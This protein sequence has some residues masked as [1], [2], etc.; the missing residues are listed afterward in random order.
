MGD[1]LWCANPTKELL[2]FFCMQFM[3]KYTL[4]QDFFLA[5]DSHL[6]A[7]W[8][9]FLAADGTLMRTKETSPCGVSIEL[10][11]QDRNHLVALSHD[12]Q[13]NI[14]VLP[15]NY[16][17]KKLVQERLRICS[18]RFAVPLL[19]LGFTFDK[20]LRLT[21]PE[22]PPEFDSSF[23]LGYF[24]GDGSIYGTT[25]KPRLQFTSTRELL[26]GVRERLRANCK[27]SYATIHPVAQ[28]AKAFRILYGG[29]RQV[30]RIRDWLYSCSPRWLSRKR[31]RFTPIDITL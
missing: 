10:K 3:R 25:R 30:A 13:S 26:Q 1:M 16:K 12:I 27:A 5:I 31:E 14:P 29:T 2:Q 9:G 4:D 22:I 24:D 8:L 23:I 6:K 28:G 21:Y 18:K 17:K 11:A 20:S 15:V 19:K 7:Y